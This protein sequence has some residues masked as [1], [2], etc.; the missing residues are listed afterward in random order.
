MMGGPA[1]REERMKKTTLRWE[2]NYR[3]SSI[4]KYTWLLRVRNVRDVWIIKIIV[5]KLEEARILDRAM[6]NTA[7]SS[8]QIRNS[9]NEAVLETCESRER[10]RLGGFHFRLA[11]AMDRRRFESWRAKLEQRWHGDPS[12][13]NFPGLCR[14]LLATFAFPISCL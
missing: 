11:V 6:K 10:K 3:N 14:W 7:T 13:I 8:N 4:S 1:K 12:N 2:K 5:E 9:N